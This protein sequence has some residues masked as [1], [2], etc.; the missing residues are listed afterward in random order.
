MHLLKDRKLALEALDSMLEIMRND[1]QVTRMDTSNVFDYR[2]FLLAQSKRFNEL[3]AFL[4]DNSDSFVDRIVFHEYSVQAFLETGKPKEAL[5]HTVALLKK[6]PDNDRY[7]SWFCKAQPDLSPEAC[8]QRLAESFGS[9]LAFTVLL[10]KLTDL[11]FVLK[12][13]EEMLKEY[14]LRLIPSFPRILKHFTRFPVYKEAI[15][16]VLLRNLEAVQQTGRLAVGLAE[17]EL[18]QCDPTCELFLLY[19][20]AHYH[21]FQKNYELAEVY[22][23]RAINHTP[24]FEDAYVLRSRCLCKAGR[25]SLAAEQALKWRQLNCGD[26]CLGQQAVEILLKDNR[27]AEADELYKRFMKSE[28]NVEK[29]VHEYQMFRYE[30][31]LAASYTEELKLGRAIGL[32]VQ[33]DSHVTENF[34]EQYEFYSFA[35]RRFTLRQLY[36]TIRFNDL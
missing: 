25:C 27:N 33:C 18:E 21:Y 16:G 36:E 11:G 24:T 31:K 17:K 14:C 22:A 34:E 5:E 28:G 2:C 8:A 6:F 9:S 12:R 4:Q 23:N 10:P 35:L 30:L 29:S 32:L 13:F 7:I 19:V 3:A 20:I 15:L 1:K 26:R